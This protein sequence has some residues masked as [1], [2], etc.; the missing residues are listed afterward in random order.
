MTKT[1]HI[2][3]VD[4]LVDSITEE[5]ALTRTC[6]RMST[7]AAS[8]ACESCSPDPNAQDSGALISPQPC[9]AT[10]RAQSAEVATGERSAAS[11]SLRGRK[12]DDHDGVTV[13]GSPAA[14]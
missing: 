12:I 9:P 11:E 8:P 14:H 7:A 1:A 13:V 6:A 3:D 4:T 2:E 10:H 5:E